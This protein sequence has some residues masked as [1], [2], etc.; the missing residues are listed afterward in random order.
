[1]S[2]RWQHWS[3][4][5]RPQRTKI[6][7]F[8]YAIDR[9][10]FQAALSPWIQIFTSERLTLNAT[11]NCNGNNFRKCTYTRVTPPGRRGGGQLQNVAVIIC[12]PHFPLLS[13][14]IVRCRSRAIH[15]V[16]F[17]ELKLREYLSCQSHVKRELSLTSIRYFLARKSLVW[18]KK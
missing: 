5:Q 4:Q 18:E 12:Y 2:N 9:R 14:I 11:S 8:M 1:M 17:C 13:A 3:V 10:V 6:E 7:P 15:F 16:T